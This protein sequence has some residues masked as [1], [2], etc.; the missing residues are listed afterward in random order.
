VSSRERDLDGLRFRAFVFFWSAGTLFH[1]GYQGRL[2]HLD[3]AA[4]VSFAALYTLLRPGSLPAFA[5]LLALQ[6]GV[7]A[8]EM[9]RVPNHWLLM[10]VSAAGL[11]AILLPALRRPEADRAAALRDA[12]LPIRAQIGIVYLWAAFHKLNAGFF[13]PAGSCAAYPFTAVGLA[14]PP[15]LIELSAASAAIA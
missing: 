13:D 1:Q 10:G 3:A 15:A 4:P 12:L 6:L 5:I 7:V 14:A 2:I 11:L 8:A 9:P